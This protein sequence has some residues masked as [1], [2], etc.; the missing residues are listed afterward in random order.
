MQRVRASL[1]AVVLAALAVGCR[2]GDQPPGTIVGPARH[3]V[4]VT[5][6]AAARRRAAETL[7][8]RSSAAPP[9]RRIL[10]GDLH[11]HTTYSV[12]AYLYSLPL[13]GGDGAH[14][15]ADACDFA[16]WC[17]GVDFFAVTDHAEGLTPE[18][19]QA[20]IDSIRQCDAIARS[21]GEVDL[22]PF[23]GF[24]WT[25]V[26]ATPQAHFGHR[27]IV[28]R[29]LGDED[30]PVRPISALPRSVLE[31]A[32]RPSVLRLAEA[33]ARLAGKPYADFLWWIGRLAAIPMCPE[34]VATRDLP[35]DCRETAETPEEL[36]E[37]LDQWGVDAL[38]IPH[39]LSWGIHAPLRAR[40]D[41]QLTAARVGARY[42]RVIE[43]F[44]GH[45]NSE[46]YR[47]WRRAE[48]TEDGGLHCP[49]PTPE[50]LPCCWQAGEIMRRRCGDLPPAE[51]ERRVRA[52]RRLAL[53]AGTAPHLVFPDT[54]PGDWLDCDQCR[55]CFKPAFAPRFGMSAQYGLALSRPGP[56]G[57]KPLRFRWGFV[58]SSDNH[59]ARPGTGY[60]QAA[61]T[62]TTDVYGLQS[63]LAARLA[64][65]WIQGAAG[66]PAV[67]QPARR[68]QHSFQGLLD[69]ERVS[70]FFYAGGLVAVHAEARD[71]DA[72][73]AALQRREVY[74]TSGPRILLWF[75]LINAPEGPLPMGSEATLSQP[76]TFEVRAVG[77]PIQLPG[78][79]QSTR[80]VL[81][82]DRLQRL[83][84]GE[85]YHPGERR[86]R[87]EAVEVVRI[88]P[89]REAGEK[90]AELIQDP[91]RR[92]LCPPDP[93]GCVVRFTD[94]EPIERGRDAVYYVRVLQE[95]TPAINGGGYRTRYDSQG[96]A[97]AI[98]PCYADWRGDPGDDCLQPVRER[99]WSS[100]IF[101]D[102]QP[103]DLSSRQSTPPERGQR[104]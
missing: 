7:A 72:I 46:E 15:P 16:R 76:P 49:E 81:P 57:T 86:L 73:W 39:G 30:I 62:M 21:G 93:A 65:R 64:R 41:N 29:G 61:R 92:F 96:N 66:D 75:D 51:C 45:G 85:C 10:F 40:L 33:A 34:G 95:P 94:P 55:D 50:F 27:N 100:P 79:P 32:P 77:A 42:Q 88:F 3:S 36:F 18:R 35:E 98:Q 68:E 53:E 104:R 52:A 37:K 99:A 97:V 14:P 12:D 70:S 11:V 60:K 82:A 24:E 83:C 63:R 91:W 23:V 48:A 2:G 1:A 90:P 56:E 78:C 17:A 74:A 20:T 19:W 103:G 71:R 69:A 47:P 31:R 25:Q 5:A 28:F 84:A 26:G 89:M 6:E 80:A 87:I 38:V 44:S 101:V 9:R 13:L 43:V 8:G 22:V 54:G 102:V 67:P 58:A 4:L 59:S